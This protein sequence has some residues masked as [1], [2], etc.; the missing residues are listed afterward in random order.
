MSFDVTHGPRMNPSHFQ[1]PFDHLGLGFRARDR[2]PAGSAAMIG[3]GPANDAVDWIK[4]GHGLAERFEQDGANTLGRNI[5]ISAFRETAATAVGRQSLTLAQ[6][7]VFGRMQRKIDSAG[8]RDS[9]FAAEQAPASQMDGQQG[10]RTHRV[11]TQ[12]GSAEIEA[13]RNAV[14]N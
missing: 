1:S 13:I 8:H 5:T 12:A 6:M 9:T 11:H 7:Q 14:R 4:V 10:R 2:E 3:G